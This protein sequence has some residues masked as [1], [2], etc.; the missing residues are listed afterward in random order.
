MAN[1]SST[2]SPEGVMKNSVKKHATESFR[3]LYHE[4]LANCKDANLAAARALRKLNKRTSSQSK[5][6]PLAG[7]S[8]RQRALKAA[9]ALLAQ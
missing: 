1:V 7:D 2:S 3:T 8:E 5:A 6:P 4:E 9:R